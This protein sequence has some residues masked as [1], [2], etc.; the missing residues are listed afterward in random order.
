M[1]AVNTVDVSV[2]RRRDETKEGDDAC[3]DCN[4]RRNIP[5]WRSPS[6]ARPVGLSGETT[7]QAVVAFACGVNSWEYITNTKHGC[8]N[9]YALRFH[10]I[11]IRII[12]VPLSK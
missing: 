3:R 2:P 5:E 7:S 4:P 1:A 12:K 9:D 10:N 6:A 8:I 11:N